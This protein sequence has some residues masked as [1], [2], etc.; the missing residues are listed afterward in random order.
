LTNRRQK[1]EVNSPSATQSVCSDWGTLKH[2]VP[3]RSIP[4]PLLFIIHI[5][6]LSMRI[7]DLSEPILFADGTSVIISSGNFEDFCS[8]SYLVLFHMIKWFAANNLVLNLDK[9]NIMKFKTRNS[10]HS[11]LHIGYKEEYREEREN[12]KFIGL[13]IDNHINWMNHTEEMIPKLSGACYA[14]R[15]MVP[16]SNINTLMNLLCIPLFYYKIW[17]QLG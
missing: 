14:I 1:V 12:T 6:D 9:M 5:N 16:V 3:R 2:E 13:Q 8:V 10:E 11:T 15:S 4:G 7:N 17:N